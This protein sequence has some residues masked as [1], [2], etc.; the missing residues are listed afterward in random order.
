MNR[1]DDNTMSTSTSGTTPC[2]CEGCRAGDLP[3]NPFVAL[4][5]A[6]GMLLGEEDFRA[7]MGNPRGKQM[8]HSAWLHG[9]GVVWGYDVV[10]DGVWM[11]KIGEGLAVD[12]IGREL[13]NETTACLDVRDLVKTTHARDDTGSRTWTISACLVA[14][15][16][17]CLSAPVPTLADPCDVTRKH[18]DYSRVIERVRFSLR[19]GGCPPPPRPYH[20]ARVLLGLDLLDPSDPAGQEAME[21]R[22]AVAAAR[23]EQRP[24]ELVKQFRKLVSLDSIDLRPARETGDCFPTL[25][26]LAEEDAA[27][28]L[29]F[30][31]IDVRERDGGPEITKVRIDREVRTALLPTATIQELTCGL[32]PALIGDEGTVDAGG[33]RVI[34]DKV[35]LNE[36]GRRLVI[37]VTAPLAK[38]SVPGTVGITSLTADQ[39]GGW[40]V[41]DI[42]QTRYEEGQAAI[43]VDLADRPINNLIRVVVKGTG[44]K[45]VM[46]R[47]P[48]VPLAGLVGGPPGTRHDG[49]D[50][51]WTLQNPVTG[52][53]ADTPPEA[54]DEGDADDEKE[55][56]R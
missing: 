46:G 7:L 27:V 48:A 17:T 13:L 35:L 38:S 3:V 22:Q 53:N 6:Y 52:R 56:G 28:V 51:V 16:D 47:D 14:E 2:D 55:A 44:P 32:A 41:E 5:V 37:P 30:V 31:E 26:P 45:P 11:L 24:R 49:H 43:V 18:D 33:P 29:A 9:S 10:E 39:A 12:G 40:V 25:F 21:A 54:A 8:L 34:G 23:P 36:N 1:C 42:Y 20:R 4:R 19:E 50:A 15:F